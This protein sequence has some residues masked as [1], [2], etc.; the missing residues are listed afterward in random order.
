MPA[1]FEK[2]V[3]K[4][5][6]SWKAKT[7]SP[8]GEHPGEEEFASFFEHKLPK[9]EEEN[10]KK[11]VLSCE[12]CGKTLA[13]SI[14]AL[15]A[16]DIELPPGLIQKSR[17]LIAGRIAQSVLEIALRLKDKLL[18]IVNTTGDVLVGQELVPAAV[19]RSRKIKDFK[20]EV[21]VLKDFGPVRIE[22]RIISQNGNYFDL[23]VVIR[24]NRTQQALKDLRVSLIKADVE[25]E[26]YL[27]DS[28]KVVFE[29]L[30]FGKYSVGISGAGGNIASISID[31]K[32]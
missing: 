14:L 16:G 17:E 26:S 21:T 6:E 4:V 15:S 20:D 24:D 9:E 8:E 19:L 3:K 22:A 12:E 31:M 23:Q 29:N 28:G 18:E 11:H 1:E 32:A 10:F 25:L 5:Y 30:L 2:L 13:D 27:S 7:A